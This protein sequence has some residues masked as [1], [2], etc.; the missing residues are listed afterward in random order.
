MPVN[1]LCPFNW[2]DESYVILYKLLD[3]FVA[4]DMA[5]ASSLPRYIIVALGDPNAELVAS[6]DLTSPCILP[7]HK[8][9]KERNLA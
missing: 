1:V 3:A 8:K 7:T 6:E 5:C 9:A 2:G 4:K